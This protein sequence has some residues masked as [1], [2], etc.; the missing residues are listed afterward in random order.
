[1]LSNYTI[2]ML[3][4]EKYNPK[5]L[6]TKDT[7]PRLLIIRTIQSS[8]QYIVRYPNG[9]TDRINA[10]WLRGNGIYEPDHASYATIATL[11]SAVEQEFRRNEPFQIFLQ[12]KLPKLYSTI[13]QA[14]EAKN[15]ARQ[16]AQAAHSK[17]FT[18]QDMVNIPTLSEAA[19]QA[20]PEALPVVATDTNTMSTTDV[21]LTSIDKS[22]KT[23]I[24]LW[25]GQPNA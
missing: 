6:S 12:Q 20:A 14:I 23:L 5:F 11:M 15:F 7:T 3:K 16:E 25:G 9:D 17:A 8:N 24:Q 19:R 4:K 2:V 10:D 13:S 18:L 1:M 22:L 21:L